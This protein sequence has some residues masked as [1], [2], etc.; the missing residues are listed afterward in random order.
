MR[1]NSHKGRRVTEEADVIE[2]KW[3]QS[4]KKVNLTNSVKCCGEAMWDED[5]KIPWGLGIGSHNALVPVS[6]NGNKLESEWD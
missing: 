4:V 5:Q 1:S 6:R 3:S 2:A